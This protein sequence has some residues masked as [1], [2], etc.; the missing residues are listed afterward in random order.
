[1]V[2]ADKHD[3][4]SLFQSLVTLLL[5]KNSHCLPLVNCLTTLWSPPL[6]FP[7]GPSIFPD[8]ESLY[9]NIKATHATEII[10]SFLYLNTDLFQ[11]N[12]ISLRA[13][14]DFLNIIFTWN[15]FKYKDNYYLQKIGLRM[16]CACGPSI[17]N[18]YI[19]ILEKSY[20]ERNPSLFYKRF[21]DDIFMASIT[22]LNIPDLTSLF[23]YLK[24]NIIM[25]NV[26]IFLN[27]EISFN[28]L[29]KSLFFKLYFTPTNTFSY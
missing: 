24:L 15:V 22:E 23:L 20:L 17:V 4:G 14:K 11:R 9:T 5:K 3:I 26:V 21:I 28:H 1:M 18:I 25:G 6:V 7:A 16:G 19:Y 8:F 12:N 2:W 29:T 10:S 13:F 27:L